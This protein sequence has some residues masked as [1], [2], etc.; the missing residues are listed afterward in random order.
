MARDADALKIQKWAATSDVQDPELGGLS[1]STGWDATY[2]QPG[3]NVPKREHL[4]QLLREHSGIGRGDQHSRPTGVGLLH[5]LR[6]SG[7][8]HGLRRQ[9]LC[10]SP[11]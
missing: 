7:Y 5:F 9:T 6:A 11:E 8:G 1:R 4:N 2:S 3:G 10:V